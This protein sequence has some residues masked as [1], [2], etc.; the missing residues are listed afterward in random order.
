MKD[1]YFL[2]D[3]ENGFE[4]FDTIEKRDAEAEDAIQA[5]LDDGWDE[6]VEQVCCGVITRKAEKVNVTER[7]D[8]IDGDGCDKDGEYW[9]DFLYKCNYKMKDID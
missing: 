9:G 1:K 8:V 4:V 7:P 5:Y 2:Y 6:G 3:P